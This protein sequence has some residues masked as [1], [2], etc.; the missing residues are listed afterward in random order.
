MLNQWRVL[1]HQRF[2]WVNWKKKKKDSWI[3]HINVSVSVSWENYL[4]KEFAYNKGKRFMRAEKGWNSFKRTV[5][6]AP[7]LKLLT[8]TRHHSYYLHVLRQEVLVRNTEVINHHQPEEFRK[9]QKVTP[10]VQP[11]PRILAGIHLGWTMSVPPERT[12][13]QND[14]SETTRIL[15]PSP[16]NPRPWAMWQSSSPGFPYPTALCLSA[17][18]Q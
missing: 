12:P 17:S 7:W 11:P 16:Q 18:S 13:S 14:W 9:G 8:L 2:P 3:H 6:E 4:S 1:F 15:I 5:G 10:R